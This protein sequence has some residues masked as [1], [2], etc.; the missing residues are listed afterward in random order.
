MFINI[1]N[2]LLF[3][4]INLFFSYF[5]IKIKYYNKL[6]IMD[7]NTIL[8]FIVIAIVVIFVIYQNNNQ[9]ESIEQFENSEV[10]SVIKP[11]LHDYNNELQHKNIT[12]FI[13]LINDDYNYNFN[14]LIKFYE[15]KVSETDDIASNYSKDE[16]IQGTKFLGHTLDKEH[17]QFSSNLNNYH[18]YQPFD[19]NYIKEPINLEKI[20]SFRDYDSTLNNSELNFPTETNLQAIINKQVEN[21]QNRKN[22]IKRGTDGK[23]YFDITIIENKLKDKFNS[24]ISELIDRDITVMAS[25]TNRSGFL[26]ISKETLINCFKNQIN[27]NKFFNDFFREQNLQSRK[28]NYQPN[29]NFTEKINNLVKDLKEEIINKLKQNI[30]TKSYFTTEYRNKFPNDNNYHI[31]DI[32]KPAGLGLDIFD[33]SL[34]KV[35][36]SIDKPNDWN[37]IL[38]KARCDRDNSRENMLKEKQFDWRYYHLRL[39]NRDYNSTKLEELRGEGDRTNS[40]RKRLE[41]K[42]FNNVTKIQWHPMHTYTAQ[43]AVYQLQINGHHHRFKDLDIYI[44]T[45]NNITDSMLS[46]IDEINTDL[47]NLKI[48][49]YFNDAKIINKFTIKN[50]SLEMKKFQQVNDNKAFITSTL[51]SYTIYRPKAPN[52]FVCLGDVIIKNSNNN[53]TN[54]ELKNKL[55]KKIMCIP[56]SCYLEIRSW[57]DDD[58][59]A[60]I[61]HVNKE[62]SS[63]SNIINF[64]VNPFTNTFRTTTESLDFNNISEQRKKPPGK[65]GRIAKCPDVS[66][67]DDVVNLVNRHKKIVSRCKAERA[68]NDELPVKSNDFDT[69]EQ[70]DYINNIY[71]QDQRI[72]F[73]KKKANKMLITEKNAEVSKREKNRQDLQSYIEKQRETIER[74]LMKLKETQNQIEINISYPMRVV[75]NVIQMVADS[76]QPVEKKIEIIKQLKEITDTPDYKDKI[77]KVLQS[78]P[79]LDLS[80]HWERDGIPCYGCDYS[81]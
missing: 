36:T 38:N 46:V 66:K 45:P 62:N 54:K 1:F 71:K 70:S 19:D 7:T 50:D 56:K 58:R 81:T 23:Y 76:N 32:F 72:K 9:K 79:D 52:K 64:Y 3:F 33:S 22:Y 39:D 28:L 41:G 2:I 20:Y 37:T 10:E 69:M 16:Y 49:E 42:N 61:Y 78:C 63:Q 14:N 15:I 77:D 68:V 34:A 30:K 31:E 17:P 43:L 57:T 24:N 67:F 74:G 40:I 51:P 59:V 44:H 73:L 47:G 13:N 60:S 21:R 18:V 53:D 75:K 55:K 35:S 27:I 65:V 12:T 4:I 26:K 8:I 11:K 29:H 80:N 25:Y 5:I 48:N 6:M